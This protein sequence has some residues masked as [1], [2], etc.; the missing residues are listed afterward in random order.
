MFVGLQLGQIMSTIDGT[1]VATALPTIA[2]DLGGLSRISWV[3]TAYFL[4]QVLSLP[5]MG[6]LGDLYGRTRLWYLAIAVFITGSMLCG[7]AGS[8]NQ[9]LVFRA[10]QGL[11]G[12]GLGTLAMAIVADIVPARQLGRWL[13]YQGA[14]FAVSSIVGPLVGGLFIDQLSWR[15]SF[16]I[17]L[18]IALVALA[19]VSTTLHLPDKRIPHAIDFAGGALLTGAL[20]SGVVLVSAGGEDL[21]WTSPASFALGAGAIGLGVLFVARQRRAPEPVVPL[22]LFADRVVRVVLA[23]NL[24]SGILLFCGIFFLPVFLQEVAGV[25]PLVSGLLLAPTMFGA[26]FGTL[27]AGRRVE[28][29]GRY[30][31]WP[32]AG[33][34]LMTIGVL[35]LATLGV[36][37]PA[38]VAIAYGGVLGLGVGFVMQTSL[39]ALQNSVEH[40]DLGIATST[41]LLFR[42]LGGAIGPS[43]FGAVLNA[44]LADRVPRTAAVFADALPA[45]FL[46]AV[47]V[48]LL[49][50]VAALRLQERPLR[51]HAHFGPDTLAAAPVV[52]E[53]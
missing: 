17:N 29:V 49:S 53:D 2:R 7:A 26:A 31:Y 21:A 30:R 14:I 46:T 48:G 22:R 33:S 10:V 43:V 4:G 9:L 36:S 6:K 32:I 41:A 18:P 1:I 27:V 23:L 44:G 42:I 3:V 40:R 28:R 37:T 15:W 38:A 8:L 19:I 5:L 51:E 35:L 20:T 47:P 16:Y 13:G 50:I 12:G 25:S 24:T 34:V 45:V 39:L 52:V 11:G